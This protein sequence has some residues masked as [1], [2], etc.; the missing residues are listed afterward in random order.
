[1]PGMHAVIAMT[2]C[3]SL[4]TLVMQGMQAVI[5]AVFSRIAMG[6]ICDVVGPRLG[7]CQTSFTI[8]SALVLEGS[9]SDVAKVPTYSPSA[10]HQE[11]TPVLRSLIPHVS[12]HVV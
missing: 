8:K 2:A 12:N 7:E 10:A 6:G 5:A 1:M 11:L 4:L 3:Y 9:R